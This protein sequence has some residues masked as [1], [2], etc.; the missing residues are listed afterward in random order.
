MPLQLDCNC[1]FHDVDTMLDRN[2]SCNRLASAVNIGIVCMFVV[3][4]FQLLL[5]FI[6]S[7]SEPCQRLFFT[8]TLMWWWHQAAA[9]PSI[10]IIRKTE[11]SRK[12]AT[13]RPEKCRNDYNCKSEKNANQPAPN[14]N[15]QSIES[16]ARER[17]KQWMR[18]M[19]MYIICIQSFQCNL[20]KRVFSVSLLLTTCNGFA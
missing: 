20:H 15:N 2:V 4:Q 10:F 13:K 12:R 1:L 6:A 17:A 19:L 14:P 7:I 5:A 16:P 18:Q 11:R 9:A 3:R 8:F